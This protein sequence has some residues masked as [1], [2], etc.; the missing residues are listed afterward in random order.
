[1]FNRANG[2]RPNAPN[3]AIVLTDGVSNLNSERTIPEA[4]AAKKADIHMF[5]IGI[6]LAEQ[7]D[8]INKLASPP[9]E[10]NRFLVTNFDE[11]DF[12]RAAV[13]DRLCKSRYH[14]DWLLFLAR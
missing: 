6:G 10:E 9:I 14:V 3:V 4:I 8:E 11:L 12:I 7:T 1:M 5:V 2:D 13:Y